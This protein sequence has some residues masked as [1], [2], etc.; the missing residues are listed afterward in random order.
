MQV[1]WKQTSSERNVVAN[2]TGQQIRHWVV[3]KIR[4]K[5]K[6]RAQ[7][8]SNQLQPTCKNKECQQTAKVRDKD[9][10]VLLNCCYWTS[11]KLSQMVICTEWD[12][13]AFQLMM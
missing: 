9:E 3:S 6:K 2:W 10:H 8:P 4:K 12:T 1:V 11:R 7:S 5:K 13:I